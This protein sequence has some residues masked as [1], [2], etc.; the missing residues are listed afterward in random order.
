[1]EVLNL[2]QLHTSALLIEQQNQILFAKVATDL[3]D[4]GYSIQPFALP[5]AL[6]NNLV[7]QVSSMSPQA[8]VEAGIGRLNK[9]M[10][11]DFV[12]RDEICWISGNSEAGAQWLDWTNKLQTYLNQHLFLGLFSF[13]SHFAHYATGSFYKRHLDAFKG[14]ANRVLSV[15]AYLNPNWQI[16][17]G[18]ELVLYQDELDT[19]GLKVIPALG[20]LAIFLS[21]EFPHEVLPAKRDRYSIAGW[22]R[23]NASSADRVDPPR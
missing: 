14:Q 4:K 22:Y 23:I 13:E 19:Q 20:T 8:F 16:G 18:G 2:H 1:M 10:H 17:D 21:E 15:V 12:R 3:I 11:N 5:I 9:H 6:S 7:T